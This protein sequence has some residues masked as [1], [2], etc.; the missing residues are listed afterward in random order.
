MEVRFYPIPT[1]FLCTWKPDITTA[2]FVSILQEA[3]S[4]CDVIVI[5]GKWPRTKS[6][7]AR[8]DEF[9]K[10]RIL[11]ASVGNTGADIQFPASHPDVFA[12]GSLSTDGSVKTRKSDEQWWWASNGGAAADFLVPRIK[13]S[14]SS[15]E[16]VF[17]GTSYGASF[18]GGISAAFLQANR[19]LLKG[20][21]S[22]HLITLGNP[23]TELLLIK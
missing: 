6:I 19:D 21:I 15:S 1:P 9:G 4:S 3:A 2:S 7:I 5:T 20:S 17:S 18:I 8:L 22:S 12:V 14:M 23:I 11:V 16:R 10:E 13:L